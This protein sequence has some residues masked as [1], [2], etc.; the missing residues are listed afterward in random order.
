MELVPVLLAMPGCKFVLSAKLNQ[1][2]LEGEFSIHRQGLGGGDNP[3][4]QQFNTKSN[5]LRVQR[6]QAVASMRGNTQRQEA[7]HTVDDEPLPKRRYH[8][9]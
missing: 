2:P 5:L 6:T 4:V 3:T 7:D 8:R 9:H 1:D